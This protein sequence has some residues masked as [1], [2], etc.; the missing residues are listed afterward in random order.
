MVQARSSDS[1]KVPLSDP[2]NVPKKKPN[3]NAKARAKR[4]Q[5]GREQTHVRGVFAGEQVGRGAYRVPVRLQHALGNT[6]ILELTKG[7]FIDDR[8]VVG[9]VEKARGNPG[10]R[11]ERDQ[12]SQTSPDRISTRKVEQHRREEERK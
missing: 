5:R 6:M 4:S 8:V 1:R 7:P 12:I 2:L 11:D 9:V 10:L 3:G